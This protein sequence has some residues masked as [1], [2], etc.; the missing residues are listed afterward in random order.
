MFR[1]NVF[2]LCKSYIIWIV[3]HF[4]CSNMYTKICVPYTLVGFFQSPFLV[5][6]PQ[7]KG[8]YWLNDFSKNN[9]DNMWGVLI[10]WLITKCK[11]N[12]N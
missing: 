2:I 11:K 10:I 3:F 1:E 4:V 7:C 8:L 5:L 12:F 6:T 9:I